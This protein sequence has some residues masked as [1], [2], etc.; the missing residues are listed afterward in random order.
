MNSADQ[1]K[2]MC[3]VGNA[4]PQPTGTAGA[5][6]VAPAASGGAAIPG[7]GFAIRPTR[8]GHRRSL[9]AA[10][11]MGHCAPAVMAALIE[12]ND[13]GRDNAILLASAM[14]GGIGNSG[15]ECGALTSSILFLGQR[16][17]NTPAS[18]GVPA[19]IILSERLIERFGEVHGGTRCDQIRKG[20]KNPLPCMKAMVSAPQ[21]V[22]EV[23]G[24]GLPHPDDECL[25]CHTSGLLSACQ[26]RRF[27]CVHS[28]FAGLP[29]IVPECSRL[30]DMTY[31]LIGGFA[32]SG[33]TC[34][35]AA[36][37]V[38]AIGLATGRIEDS[39]V[40]VAGML[41]RM[42][43]GGDTMMMAD[44]VNNFNPAINRG[45][46]LL[47]WFSKTYGTVNCRDLT[48]VDIRES[49]TAGRYFGNGGL[50]RCNEIAGAVALKVREIIK[51]GS[52]TGG[53]SPQVR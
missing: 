22:E 26:A 21:L 34:T 51:N 50:D 36:A 17:G 40:R 16:Y 37:G 1:K 44:P 24:Q 49:E 30:T 31:P 28:V 2:R 47:E 5:C 29:G 11:R 20:G 10:L 25:G 43:I 27:H 7:T 41:A 8:P 14:A 9:D 6:G 35:A 48:G 46:R 32:L 12:D 4:A 53:V 15:A 33:G 18:G 19:S 39:Y 52:S 3:G 42:F 23:I 45:G 13:P 38:L